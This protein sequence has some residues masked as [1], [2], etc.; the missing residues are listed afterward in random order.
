MSFLIVP[1]CAA[2]E[3]I[4]FS[5][6]SVDP[7]TNERPKWFRYLSVFKNLFN[8]LIALITMHPKFVL[9]KSV[10]TFFSHTKEESSHTISHYQ[11]GRIFVSVHMLFETNIMLERYQEK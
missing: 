4:I 3:D 1:M 10:A 7:A 11:L 9:S 5:M 2:V 6:V 8:I